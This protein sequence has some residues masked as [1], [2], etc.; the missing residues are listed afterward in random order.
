[1]KE[2]DRNQKDQGIDKIID[3][4]MKAWGLE[5]KMKEMDVIKA[6]PELMGQGIAHRTEKLSIRNK[7]LHIKLNSS[8]MRDELHYGRNVIIQRVNEFAG[9][10]MINDIWFE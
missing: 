1:M 6:W 10:E 5:G 7:V 9:T 4:M 8:V 3:K 2:N